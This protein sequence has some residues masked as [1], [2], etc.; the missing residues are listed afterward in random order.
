MFGVVY[1]VT[2]EGDKLFRVLEAPLAHVQSLNAAAYEL[3]RVERRVP[4]LDEQVAQH[5]V[6]H[7]WLHGGGP[8][9]LLVLLS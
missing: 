4:G 3:L 8:L 2:E 7:V 6:Q 1:R 5:D 9:L